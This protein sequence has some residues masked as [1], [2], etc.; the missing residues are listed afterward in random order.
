MNKRNVTKDFSATSKHNE[1]LDLTSML[2]DKAGDPMDKAFVQS[3][4]AGYDLE[5]LSGLG[6]MLKVE[7][8]D[9]LAI[10]GT[11][12]VT[13]INLGTKQV[14]FTKPI[15]ASP[16]GLGVTNY[17]ARSLIEVLDRIGGKA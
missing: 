11:H 15:T 3:V 12:W 1:G 16:R 2:S 8:F 9:K 6:L 7:S 14:I 17:W 13:F 5:G 4:V 10:K